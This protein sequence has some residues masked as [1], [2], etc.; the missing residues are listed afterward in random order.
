VAPIKKGQ[1]LGSVTINGKALQTVDHQP[2]TFTLS[3]Q[4]NVKRLGF[5]QRLFN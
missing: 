3:S 4:Q 1:R 2:L 5:W